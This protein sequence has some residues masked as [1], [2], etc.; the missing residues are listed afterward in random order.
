M[1]TDVRMRR[2]TFVSGF[3]RDMME[4]GVKLSEKVLEWMFIESTF[5]SVLVV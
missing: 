5:V 1:T 4:I 2:E 3:A